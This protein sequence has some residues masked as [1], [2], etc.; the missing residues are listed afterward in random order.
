MRSSVWDRVYALSGVG[1]CKKYGTVVLFLHTHVTDQSSLM[2]VEK[3][4]LDEKSG[5]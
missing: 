4:I 3:K 2:L 5:L 1:E